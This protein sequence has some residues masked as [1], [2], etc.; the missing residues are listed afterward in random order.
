MQNSA[1]KKIGYLVAI[2]IVLLLLVLFFF[3]Y[4][5]YPDSEGYIYCAQ[6]SLR[7]NQ[8]YP[9]KEGLYELP[10]LW[11]IGAINAVAASLWLFNSV[12]PLL[13][14]YTLMKG[15][16]LLLT[17]KIALTCFGKRAACIACVLYLL[18][19]A[20]YGEGTSLHSEVPFVFFIL[21]AVWSSL[22]GRYVLSGLLFGCADYI[23][24]FALIFIM[25]VVL[26]D[27]KNYKAYW[28]MLAVYVAFIM[29]IGL[30]NY[31]SKGEFVYKAKTGWMAL[32]Q[33]HWDHDSEKTTPNPQCVTGNDKLT[34]TQKDELWRDMFFDWLKDNKS[35]YVRQLPVKVFNT[36][37]SD[38]I[39]MCTFLSKEEKQ[40]QYMYQPL[41][42]HALI[43]DFPHYSAVQWLTVVN[44]LF[45]YAV[46]TMFVLSIKYIKELRLQ[47]LIIIFGTLFIAFVGHGES[48]FHIP[49]MPF[50]IMAVSYYISKMG[51]MRSE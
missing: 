23:R 43:R 35:E 24:P 48:R 28:K 41:S 17:Y 27:L 18:Y 34:Y 45:Y 21:S 3:G 42:L 31:C 9:F 49:F 25:V 39:G 8:F 37:V 50:V 47:W 1:D 40:S 19:P 30:S 11:N 6:E 20:N 15:F 5:P 29:S 22:K 36:Y 16:S 38:N 7:H 14:I 51:I 13:I 2:Y 44:L 46:M 32:S 33:Y 26:K 4:T 10:F 12:T